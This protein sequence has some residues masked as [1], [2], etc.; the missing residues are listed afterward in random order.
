MWIHTTRYTIFDFNRALRGEKE[1][2]IEQSKSS[3]E[4]VLLWVAICKNIEGM[5]AMSRVAGSCERTDRAEPPPPPLA[6]LRGPT[7]HN[8]GY[9]KF[10]I[11]IQTESIN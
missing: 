9:D 4:L 1:T 11:T 6:A 8:P 10:V 5:L 2:K 3:H 7:N